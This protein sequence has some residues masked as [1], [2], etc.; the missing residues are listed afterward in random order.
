VDTNHDRTSQA[1]EL[2][3]LSDAGVVAIDLNYRQSGRRDEFGNVLR[4]RAR[5]WLADDQSEWAWDVFF[6]GLK[7]S[8]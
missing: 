3:T 2:F 8:R 1:S 7:K 5:I 4:Y 6:S